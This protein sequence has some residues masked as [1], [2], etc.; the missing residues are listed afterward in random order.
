MRLRAA[1]PKPEARRGA[2]GTG[3]ELIGVSEP[4]NPGHRFD[5]NHHRLRREQALNTWKLARCVD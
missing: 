4:S 5:A 2:L 1:A 3:C